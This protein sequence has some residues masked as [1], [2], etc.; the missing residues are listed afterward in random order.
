[1]YGWMPLTAQI[2]E[3]TLASEQKDL[4]DL[5]KR[6]RDSGLK[7]IIL[8]DYHHKDKEIES[9]I[10]EIDP[11]TFLANIFRGKYYKNR[12]NILAF[13][14]NYWG[15][16]EDIH[17]KEDD[18]MPQAFLVK[19][20]FFDY[21]FNRGDDD[22]KLLWE[23][24]RQAY[25]GEVDPDLF[26]RCLQIKEVRMS[27]LTMGLFWIKPQK[28]L[29]TDSN[30]ESILKPKYSGKWPTDYESYVALLAF[31]KEEYKEK[32]IYE[33][34]RELYEES[35]ERKRK[36]EEEAKASA[37]EAEDQ[38][39]N[40]SLD[41]NSIQEESAA[42]TRY[43]DEDALRD[44]FL[45]KKDFRTLK[46]L[47][48][49]KKNLI[50]Q[51]PPGVG[52]SFISKRLAYAFLEEEAKERVQMIQ[53]HPSYAYEDFIQGYRPDGDGNFKRKD[54]VF[55]L[56]CK[57]AQESPD[58]DFVFII[59]E[60]NRGNLARIFGECLLLIENDKRLPDYQV[61]L[62][63]GDGE[64]SDFYVPS[65][66]YILGLMNT[67]DRSLSLV[68]YALRRRFAFSQLDPA[69]T[70]DRF[71]QALKQKGASDGLIQK[72]RMRMK[73]LNEKISADQEL[74]PGFQ[75]G[76]SFFCPA[77]DS[78][79]NLRGPDG[80]AWYRNVVESE[81]KFLLEEYWPVDTNTAEG[82]VKKLLGE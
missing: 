65:N 57:K 18:V 71:S 29:C 2:V 1:M 30:T 16:T 8:R 46:N 17:K 55:Y 54:G 50:L 74:G 66:V 12:K 56:F 67:A 42:Y 11:F 20:W 62:T 40:D 47:L 59:D 36:A 13:L 28:Y 60:I 26:D 58:E 44:V 10:N 69:F 31:V 4:I 9:P 77:T 24:A 72:I 73:L 27:K 21:K 7:P 79:V 35:Q 52:K 5:T 37:N 6:M 61:S 75:I 53:F 32:E 78:G 80:E 68:D 63:Y 49:N 23:L 76:H 38:P 15:L 45:I 43:S 3:K 33:L 25:K 70:S 14:K 82:E 48:R 64:I 22:T 51:G 41:G 81:I 39:E 34:S 19:S